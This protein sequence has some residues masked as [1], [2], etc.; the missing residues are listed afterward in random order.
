MG[1]LAAGACLARTL[2]PICVSTIYASYGTWATFGFMAC[3][4]TCI[5]VMTLTFHRRLVPYKYETVEENRY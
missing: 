4:M 2:C 1:I 5:L 3:V